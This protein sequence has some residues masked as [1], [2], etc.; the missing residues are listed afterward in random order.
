MPLLWRHLMLCHH[1]SHLETA[2]HSQSCHHFENTTW[3]LLKRK[4]NP[5][6]AKEREEK[7]TKHIDVALGKVSF[8]DRDVN[9]IHDQNYINEIRIIGYGHISPLA[10]YNCQHSF[11]TTFSFFRPTFKCECSIRQV[12]MVLGFSG[13]ALNLSPFDAIS[14]LGCYPMM[15][16]QKIET[17]SHLECCA[18][19]FL[20][21]NHKHEI[22]G[23]W[24]T[25]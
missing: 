22:L 1:R 24:S 20:I 8:K 14:V 25:S 5:P 10:I 13:L 6:K 18:R 4:N 12:L 15:Q 23:T 19:H 11:L 17:N 16:H 7:V 9:P 21:P 2:S 3:S